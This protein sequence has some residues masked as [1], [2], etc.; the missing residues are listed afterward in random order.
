M[1]TLL[2]CRSRG[3][4]RQFLRRRGGIMVLSVE[5]VSFSAQVRSWISVLFGAKMCLLPGFARCSEANAGWEAGYIVRQ[6]YRRVNPHVY[7]GPVCGLF[8]R[9][10]YFWRFSSH[11]HA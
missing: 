9:A 11:T 2:P 8:P 5:F 7:R 4:M 6:K 1:L 3:I 10:G